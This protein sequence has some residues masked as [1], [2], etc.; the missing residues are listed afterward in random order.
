MQ[1]TVTAVLLGDGV[2]GSELRAPVETG[3]SPIEFGMG[4]EGFG[5]AGLSDGFT[6]EDVNALV[7]FAQDI[8]F[9]VGGQAVTGLETLAKF[10]RVVVTGKNH[11]CDACPC[12]SLGEVGANRVFPAELA[13][14]DGNW[15]ARFFID[16]FAAFET[17]H[18]AFE[19][20]GI[21]RAGH[22]NEHPANAGDDQ[23]FLAWLNGRQRDE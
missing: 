23:A 13:L 2:L 22:G 4:C 18:E 1:T 19:G 20:G 12:G 6:Q 14:E 3:G 5:V 9:F 10:A 8:G 16:E 11:R 17:L 15:I 7:E 21:C